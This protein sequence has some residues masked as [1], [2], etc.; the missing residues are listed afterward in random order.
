MAVP[1]PFFSDR[2]AVGANSYGSIYLQAAWIALRRAYAIVDIAI[3]ESA[4][5]GGIG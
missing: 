1:F 5:T 4:S 2:P 3:Q